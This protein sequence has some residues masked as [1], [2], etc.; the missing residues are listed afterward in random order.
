VNFVLLALF[1]LAW[2]PAGARERRRDRANK[3]WKARNAQYAKNWKER[4]SLVDDY[5][6]CVVPSAWIMGRKKFKKPKQIAPRKQPGT[7]L[8]R[9]GGVI[10]GFPEFWQKVH[11][12]YP[13]FFEATDH[14]VPLVNT[15]LTKPIAGQLARVLHHMTA[16]VSNSLGSLITLSLNGYGHD[17]VRIA[18]GMFETAV[19]AAYLAR[20]PTEVQD[21]L[22]YHWI[23]QRR[24]LDY[25]RKE[26]TANFQHLKQSDIDDID[27][28][29][30]NVVPRFTDSRGK[31]RNDWC[32]KNLRQRA[33]AVGMG[34]LYPTF[35]G[36]ASSIH[37]GDIAGLASQITT[38]KFQTEVAPSFDAIKDAL[39]MGHNAV[40]A[41]IGNFNEVANLGLDAELQKGA[42]LFVKA[43]G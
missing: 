43:W 3:A 26:D 36:Y 6:N 30:A 23:R 14:L 37:H 24:L 17:A 41:V 2:L 13:R 16:V 20:N 28:E 38:A 12:R 27:R 35:Y 25:M 32:A 19:N 1:A 5:R 7:P 8:A 11:D 15:I 34:Q 29:Y 31:V 10:A 4:K 18:R 22:S 33:E 39:V 21:Y 40:I 42:D 9:P